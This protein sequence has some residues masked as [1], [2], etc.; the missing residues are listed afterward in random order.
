MGHIGVKGVKN[1]VDGLHFNDSDLDFPCSVCARANIK[2]SPF[3]SKSSHPATRLLQR[4][5]CDICG[6]LPSCFGN[7]RYFILFIDCFSR[8]IS[9]YLMKSRDEAH[10]H[11]TTFRS[12]TENFSGQ[13]ISILRVD[14]A[15]ELIRGKLEE[16]CKQSGITYEKTVPD[17]PNQNGVAERCN[18]TIAS[19]ARAM[20]LDANLSDWYWPFAVHAAVHI[21][22]RVPHS[23]LP[24]QKTPFEF[25]Y[26]HKPNLSHLRLF[27]SPCTSRILSSSLS[28]FDPR[29]E[30]AIFLGY[31]HNAKGYIIWVPNHNGHGGSIKIRRDVAFHD[32]P[33]PSPSEDDSPLWE[34][35]LRSEHITPNLYDLNTFNFPIQTAQKPS[36]EQ[37][38][39]STTQLRDRTAPN[40]ILVQPTNGMNIFP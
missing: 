31:A 27:G 19:M 4:I 24:P 9:L 1:A 6:P 28:K 10:V 2:R 39:H 5:H 20:L 7:Y 21:K 32:F 25:W 15:P 23:N 30:S 3:P 12:L 40:G 17:T 18:L 36:S 16:I 33:H 11:F 13:R 37:Q 34:D 14:N 29:G 26:Q 22:N 8:Y 35:V 38:S